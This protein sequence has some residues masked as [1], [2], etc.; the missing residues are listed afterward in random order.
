MLVIA[1]NTPLRYLILLGYVDTLPALYGRVIIPHAVLTELQHPHTPAVVRTWMANPPAWLEIRHTASM[2]D[3]A[4]IDLDA[5]ER[6]AILL[7]Q[8]LHA[9]LLLIDEGDGY[10]TATQRG[11][12]CMR[13]VGLLEQAGIRV[14]LD[15]PEAI[16]RLGSPWRFHQVKRGCWDIATLK[17]KIDKALEEKKDDLPPQEWELTQEGE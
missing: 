14:P 17:S 10:S 6:D 11:I 4:L 3:A 1:D 8:E 2:A 7:V 16:A 12:R 13:T 15:L 9:D 5:G